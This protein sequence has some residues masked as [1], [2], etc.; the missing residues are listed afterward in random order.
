MT[1][2]R[3]IRKCIFC[4]KVHVFELP[5]ERVDAWRNGALI[6]NVFPELTVEQLETII[7][8]SCPNCF[9]DHMGEDIP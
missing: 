7:S 5:T 9:N 3:I 8:G 2:T 4:G 6:Q 1:S